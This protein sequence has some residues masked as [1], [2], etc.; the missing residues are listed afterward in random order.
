MVDLYP[1]SD[2]PTE[3][4][5]ADTIDRA[6]VEKHLAQWKETALDAVFGLLTGDA[7]KYVCL[8]VNKTDV[9]TQ[10]RRTQIEAAFRPLRIELQRRANAIGARFELICGSAAGGMGIPVLKDALRSVATT[11]TEDAS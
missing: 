8:F 5:T 9:L 2:D 6:R 10:D 4:L 3:T 1:P 11:D 7:L